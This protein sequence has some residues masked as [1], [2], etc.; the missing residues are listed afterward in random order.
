MLSFFPYRTLLIAVLAA[1]PAALTATFHPKLPY[2]EPAAPVPKLTATSTGLIVP[3]WRNCEPPLMTAPIAPVP[4]DDAHMREPSKPP[5]LKIGAPPPTK[6]LASAARPPLT[7]AV[8]PVLIDAAVPNVKTVTPASRNDW[9]PLT[10]ASPKLP[11]SPFARAASML[12]APTM[13][14]ANCFVAFQPSAP[15]CFPRSHAYNK[16]SALPPV[17]AKAAGLGSICEAASPDDGP[18]NAVAPPYDARLLSTNPP[19]VPSSI[20]LLLY[21]ASGNPRV[22]PPNPPG[23]ICALRFSIACCV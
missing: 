13:S 4:T 10:T 18:N 6:S 22:T 15:Y 7:S 21:G 1:P 5:E 8:I 23:T 14:C 19:Y 20:V 11:A 17:S 9:V 3:F 12:V 16:F 2:S